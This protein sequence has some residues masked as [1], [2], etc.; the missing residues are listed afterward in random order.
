[1]TIP[2]ESEVELEALLAELDRLSDEEVRMQ[3]K[4]TA[5]AGGGR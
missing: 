4:Q 3:L 5:T 1:M 2:V